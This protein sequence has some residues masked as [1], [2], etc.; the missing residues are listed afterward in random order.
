MPTTSA[1]IASPL[2][3]LT[4]GG[5]SHDVGGPAGGGGVG[6]ELGVGGKIRVDVNGAWSLEA[7]EQVQPRARPA[8]AKSA[9]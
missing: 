6:N 9:G 5:D 8:G 2:L 7:A 4:A 3:G 1:E